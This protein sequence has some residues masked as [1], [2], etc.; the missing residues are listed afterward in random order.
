MT[1]T[2]YQQLVDFLTRHFT[3]IH[4]RFDAIDHRFDTIDGRVGGGFRETEGW[5]AKIE[6]A[7]ERLGNVAPLHASLARIERLLR[8]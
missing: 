3:A 4:H 8:A 7:L 1:K 2:E 6:G 5:F